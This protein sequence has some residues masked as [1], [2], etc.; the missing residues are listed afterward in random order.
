MRWHCSPFD[1]LEWI[2]SALQSW[3]PPVHQFFLSLIPLCWREEFCLQFSV[4]LLCC[5]VP[6]PNCKVNSMVMKHFSFC[7]KS[8]S[9]S[10]LLGI[11]ICFVIQCCLS[12]TFLLALA[13]LRLSLLQF[14]QNIL[15]FSCTSSLMPTCS[16]FRHCC[17][18]IRTHLLSSLTWPP[19][20][21]SSGHRI[22]SQKIWLSRACWRTAAAGTGNQILW[23]LCF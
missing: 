7:H 1:T 2:S 22:F 21:C 9:A 10:T 15:S 13:G 11:H 14:F 23:H 17:N 3:L 18:L 12:R 6:E 16:L 8:E 19:A 4:I 20:G 5:Q